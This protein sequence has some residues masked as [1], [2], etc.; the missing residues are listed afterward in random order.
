MSAFGRV[1]FQ[2]HPRR[3]VTVGGIAGLAVTVLLERLVAR[4]AGVVGGDGDNGLA[5]F[6]WISFF[7][8]FTIFRTVMKKLKSFSDA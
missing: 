6:G 4:V 7:V 1:Y 8:T 2:A 5:T 3:D